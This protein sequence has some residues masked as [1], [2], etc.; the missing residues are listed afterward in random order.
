MLTAYGQGPDGRIGVI[1]DGC[2]PPGSDSHPVW[3]DLFQPTEAEEQA[4]EALLSIDVPTA[5]D[6]RALEDSSRFYRESGALFLTAPVMGRR[7]DGP[8]SAEP[9]TFILTDSTLVTVRSNNPRAFDVGTERASARIIQARTPGGVFVSLLEGIVER[10]ADLMQEEGAQMTALAARIFDSDL[11]APTP[12]EDRKNLKTLGRIGGLLSMVLHS[13]AGFERLVAFCNIENITS[14]PERQRMA[15]TARDIEQLVRVSE[16]LQTKCGFLLD[17]LLGMTAAGQNASLRALSIATILFVPPTLIASVFG[18]NFEAMS[19]F[20]HDWGPWVA[21]AM[22][23]LAP[24]LLLAFARWN[25][26]F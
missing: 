24:S 10:I 26:W 9:V 8:F 23:A 1:K 16:A 22:M 6:R 7:T 20:R 14:G 3:I 21:F 19:W 25:K 5:I 15:A 12:R 2:P 13:L 11:T 17:A 4:V 18:M